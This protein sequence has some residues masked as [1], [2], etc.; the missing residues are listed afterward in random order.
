MLY[1]ACGDKAQKNRIFLVRCLQK[2]RDIP[3]N[4]PSKPR[5]DRSRPHA[6]VKTIRLERPTGRVP[7]GVAKAPAPSRSPPSRRPRLGSKS[8]RSLPASVRVRRSVVGPGCCKG[9]ARP[10]APNNSAAIRPRAAFQPV[11]QAAPNAT[12]R[13]PALRPFDLTN[14]RRPLAHLRAWGQSHDQT[15]N[16]VAQCSYHMAFTHQVT[17]ADIAAEPD[18]RRFGPGFRQALPPT[19]RPLK[20]QSEQA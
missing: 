12:R 7:S 2:R 14:T 18:A 16:G 3:P 15:R 6:V 8:P 11:S 1:A 5:P 9:S 4:L 17:C 10:H 19:R 13:M 20:A